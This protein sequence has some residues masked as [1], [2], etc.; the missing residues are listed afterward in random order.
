M[1]IT[2]ILSDKELTPAKKLDQTAKLVAAARKAYGNEDAAIAAPMVNTANGS[3]RFNML[4]A[5]SKVELLK[6]EV[7]AL[8][9]RA[10]EAHEHGEGVNLNKKIEE[11]LATNAKF[12]NIDPGVKFDYI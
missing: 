8:K 3:M 9:A 12:V 11:L 7:A 6:G 1:S 2:A 10:V 4:D 5:D